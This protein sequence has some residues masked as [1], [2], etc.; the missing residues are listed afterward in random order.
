MAPAKTPWWSLNGRLAISSDIDFLQL[1]VFYATI[2]FALVAYIA[3]AQADALA[4]L[5]LEQSVVANQLSLFALCSNAA[6]VSAKDVAASIVHALIRPQNTTFSA[7][8]DCMR[9][10]SSHTLGA[11]GVK[12]FPLPPTPGRAPAAPTAA[13]PAAPPA[14]TPPTSLPNAGTVA[15]LVVLITVMFVGYLIIAYMKVK[16]PTSGKHWWAETKPGPW[17]GACGRGSW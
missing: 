7:D 6:A 1:H 14:S 5:A 8:A 9:I 3:A 2:L 13:P 12:L 16:H 4:T 15:G 11:V 10:L 17:G